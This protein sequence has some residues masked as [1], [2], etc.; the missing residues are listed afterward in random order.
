MIS[1]FFHEFF[2]YFVHFSFHSGLLFTTEFGLIKVSPG[3]IVVIP[4]G[5]R[6]SVS[7]LEESSRGYV[8][9]VFG[10]HFQLPE[11]GPIGKLSFILW[12]YFSI[13][14]EET[15]SCFLYV[16]SGSNGLANPRDFLFPKAFFDPSVFENKFTVV[17]KFDGKLFE[18]KQDFSPFNVVAWHGN[19]VPYKVN[20]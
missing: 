7:I 3:E 17:H 11:L 9:E 15:S 10:S 19:Y 13:Y 18:A 5:I 14:A 20:Y 6:F 1:S 2:P 12:I 4:S 16:L 8:C